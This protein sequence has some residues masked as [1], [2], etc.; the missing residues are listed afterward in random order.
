MPARP[1]ARRE[2]HDHWLA[3][4]RKGDNLVQGQI[5]VQRRVKPKASYS[6][7]NPCVFK[8]AKF[9]S[10]LMEARLN[11]QH[12]GDPVMSPICVHHLGH[13]GGRTG[14]GGPDLIFLPR[15]VLREIELVNANHTMDGMDRRRRPHRWGRKSGALWERLPGQTR[16]HEQEERAKCKADDA[17]FHRFHGVYS[18]LLAESS[19]LYCMQAWVYSLLRQ[20]LLS[21]QLPEPGAFFA[22]LCE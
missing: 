12:I 21:G 14:G 4:I 13:R 2:I 10:N 17:C 19:M 8:Q 15:G 9:G 7:H 16:K 6:A 5:M 1:L 22:G 20:A 18:L 3:A 11:M